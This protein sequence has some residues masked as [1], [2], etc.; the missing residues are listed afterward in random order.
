MSES[1]KKWVMDPAACEEL[2][3]KIMKRILVAQI[4]V[5]ENPLP[6]VSWEY[7]L[8]RQALIILNGW[9]VRP[10]PSRLHT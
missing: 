3:Q 8:M 7:D 10:M 1:I 5:V 2:K 6:L 9:L 4:D